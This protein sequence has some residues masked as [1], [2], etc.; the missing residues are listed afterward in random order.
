MKA[1]LIALLCVTAVLAG[2]Y[3]TEDGV[4]VLTDSTFNS[5]VEEYEHILAEFY[6]PW[7]GHCKSL[8]PEYVKAAQQLAETNP[9]VK[10][11]KIDCTVEKELASRF[12]IQGFPT[13]KFF[14]KAIGAEPIAYE[15]GRTAPDIVNWLKKKTGPPSVEI[16]SVEDAEVQIGNNDV[17]VVFFGP[18]GTE[19]YDNYQKA[20]ASFEDVAFGH[21]GEQT[22]AEKYEAQPN[23]VVLFK[24]FDEGKN[25][26]TGETTIEAIKAFITENKDPT[27]FP[28][29]QK[30]A[31][32]IFG[33]GHDALFLIKG[34]D[35][36]SGKA[37]ESLRSIA[38][39]FKGKVA[40]S[41]ASFSDNFGSR[42]AEY[43][44]VAKEHLPAIRIVRPSKNNLK[45][46]FE[47]ELT[48]DNLKSFVHDF[49]NDKLKPFFKSAPI[50][51]PNHEENV[52]IIVGKNFDD[53]VINNDNDVI[54]EYYAPWCGHCKT[55]AP[56]YASLATKLKDV[57]GVTIAKMDATANEVD[58]L[59]IQGFPTIKFY[60][61][62]N[63][64]NPID[65]DGERTEEGFIKYLKE[66]GVNVESAGVKLDEL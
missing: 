47:H 3:A 22:V 53:V 24:K 55:L 46:I 62:G 61:K 20:A 63:K 23:S 14:S 41:I 33:E 58:G 64:Q 2:E 9:N 6:A 30:V 5:A 38:K 21:S 50:P 31:Q 60:P 51:E 54:V 34:D 42:L 19:A 44:G 12:G 43:I 1:F 26:H 28:F 16:K 57:S 45:Y 48:V 37:E 13:L 8:A 66:K 49:V 4:L 32:K 35:E 40:L 15:G 59:N 18:S 10:L 52:K 29:T 56:I 36:H 7:C 11:A 25:V 17:L 39:E 65:Y 27:I